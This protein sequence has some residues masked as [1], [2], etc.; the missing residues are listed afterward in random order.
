MTTCEQVRAQLLSY[1][2]DLL[3][4]NEKLAAAAHLGSCEGCQLALA[5]AQRQQRLLAAAAKT[6]FPNVTFERPKAVPAEKLTGASTKRAFPRPFHFALAASIFLALGLAAPATW[7]GWKTNELRGRLRQDQRDLSAAQAHRADLEHQKEVKATALATAIAGTQ[8][9]V[10]K[11]QE[12]E[13]AKLIALNKRM[14]DQQL[15]VSVIGPEVLQAGAENDYTINTRNLQNEALTA[16]LSASVVD[17]DGKVFFELKNAPTLG[18]YRLHLPADLPATPGKNLSLDVMAR[19]DGEP[20]RQLHRKI[21]LAAPVYLTHLATDKPMYRPGETVHF[22]SLTLERFSLKPV[23]DELRLQFTITGPQ[24][25]EIMKQLGSSRLRK[26]DGSTVTMTDGKPVAGIGAGEFLIP[27]TIAG[28]EFTLKVREANNRFPEQERKF[29]V[30]N[31]ANPRLNKELDFTRKSYGPGQ[32]V[33]AACS[34]TY[35]E[36][37]PVANRPVIASMFIDGKPFG[38]D[39]KQGATPLLLQ[40]DA[41]GKVSV[42]FKLPAVIDRGQASLSVQFND[43]GSVEPLIRTVPIALKKLMV[44]FFPEGGYLI[45]GAPNRVYFQARTTLGKPAELKGHIVD[46]TGATVATSVATLHDDSKPGVNQGMGR[47]AFTPALGHH[48]ELKIDEPSGM[49]GVYALPTLQADGVVLN[50]NPPGKESLAVQVT[51][52][53]KD[54]NLLIGVYC[55]G[56]LL[57]HQTVLA[58]KNEMATVELKPAAPTGGVCRVTVFEELPPGTATRLAPKAERLVYRAPGNPLTF[59]AKPNQ[60]RYVP[61]DHVKL[62]LSAFDE[63]E[64]A[65]PAVAMAAVVDKSVLTL[66]D[67]KTFHG[68]PTHYFLSTEIRRP[69]ELEYADFLVGADPK[70]P[71]ALDLLLGTQ[72]WRKFAEQHPAEF[73]KEHKEDADRLLLTM[74]QAAPIEVDFAKQE[75]QQ[76]RDEYLARLDSLEKDRKE[77][78]KSIAAAE[79]KMPAANS[80]VVTAEAQEREASQ[81]YFSHWQ[82][83]ETLGQLAWLATGLLGLAVFL[84]CL[85]LGVAKGW[86]RSPVFYAIGTLGLVG[87]VLFFADLDQLQRSR[88]GNSSKQARDYEIQPELDGWRR[89]LPAGAVMAPAPAANKADAPMRDEAGAEAK[90]VDKF[91]LQDLE[92]GRRAGG[93]GNVRGDAFGGALGGGVPGA[94]GFGGGGFGDRTAPKPGGSPAGPVIAGQPNQLFDRAFQPGQP[95]E[96]ARGAAK[97]AGVTRGMP[98]PASG[99]APVTP[100]GRLGEPQRGNVS[101]MAATFREPTKDAPPAAPVVD[102]AKQKV[103]EQNMQQGLDGKKASPEVLPALGYIIINGQNP[104][105]VKAVEKIIDA[106]MKAEQAQEAKPN[107]NQPLPGLGA[108]AAPAPAMPAPAANPIGGGDGIGGPGAPAGGFG[109]GQARIHTAGVVPKQIDEVLKDLAGR[110]GKLQEAEGLFEQ[111]FPAPEP[112]FV[113]E[114]AHVRPP[115]ISPGERKDFVDTVYW[116]PALVLPNGTLD[117][118]FQL[119]DAVTSYQLLV[120]GH[121]EDGRIGS[122]VKTFEARLPFTL[123]PKLP[124]E[125]T[126]GDRI[127]M[128]V[129]VAN[130]T[131]QSRSVRMQLEASNM[132]LLDKGAQ[133][134]S[135]SAGLDLGADSR[136]RTLFSLQP[137]AVE[138]EAQIVLE[139]FSDP[140]LDRVI[141]RVPI[142]PQGF[143]VVQARSDLLEGTAR[144]ELVLPEAWIP[145]T[146]R[147]QVT[148]YPSTL[149]SLQKGLEGLLREPNG[150]FEQTSTTNY[151][152]LLILDYLRESNQAKPELEKRVRDLLANGYAKLTSFECFEN[153]PAKRQG[154]EWFGGQAAPHEA[155]TA[156][157]LLQFRDMARVY[158][159]DKAMLERTRQYLVA[160]KD[161]QGGFQRNARALDSFGRAPDDVTNAYIVWSLTESGKD[162]DVTKELNALA[163]QSR[164]AQDPYFLALVALSL[165][166]RERTAEGITLLKTL[167]AAQKEDGHLDALRTSITG[168]G[169]R[170]LQI[171]TTALA[172]LG[173]LKANRP[174]EFNGFTQKA[175]KWIGQQRGGYG[176]FGSTQSTIL[177]LKALIAFAKMNKRNAEAGALT[178]AVGGKVA[179]RMEFPAGAQDV[180]TLDLP[181]ASKV[182]HAGNNDVQ[183]A[184]SGQNQFPYTLAWSYQV[185]SPPAAADCAVQVKTQLDRTSV[186]EGEAVHLNVTLENKEDFGQGMTVAI[187]GLP[188]GLTLPEDMKQLKD[189]SRLR[190][191]GAKPGL[192][193]AWETRGRELILYWRDLAPKQK[194]E[195]PIDLI[196]RVP[197]DYTGP[198]SRAYLYYNADNKNWIKP[199]HVT[200]AARRAVIEK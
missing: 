114:F 21:P 136:G 158:D 36:G 30:N 29:I 33:V 125:V 95:A 101:P 48:Y 131:S 96:R 147:C 141:R 171:E 88:S 124:L 185:E 73:R 57:D 200:I 103:R 130:N 64:Q 150:C 182:L 13:Q 133:T 153:G 151:P 121:T 149:A 179:A 106:R 56:R 89:N 93:G 4:D 31:F 82:S 120:F 142:V 91:G 197:G 99:P 159:V 7:F 119:G 18:S 169:G 134:A 156:Y 80:A 165:I 26:A 109:A 90:G 97:G 44:D 27:P 8:N 87:S 164:T 16:E 77:L 116:H 85:L 9:T 51:S 66:A 69:E 54:R 70:A 102:A 111:P 139:G 76:V 190:E 180:M 173:W 160:R 198:A 65:V 117:V 47:F 98:A 135:A 126:A 176:A 157:G 35:A 123:E 177:A 187:I 143:P 188:A 63:K 128:P 23:Q 129:S 199:L 75:I 41:L 62:G 110:V 71:E 92:L 162:D 68:M 20:T 170:D 137:T 10:A 43:G 104:E 32:E 15:Q 148:V 58:K 2:Y 22:R 74:G 183:V 3:D 118:E 195:V 45:A 144:S 14:A 6:A 53:G 175:I 152:N 61:G 167:G 146:L 1:V 196:A 172:V 55:R 86:R 49:E 46:E 189:H 112:M 166:N 140:Y 12:E 184:I 94:A 113:R 72:G 40:T 83:L 174:A 42:R 191:D 24:G 37:G 127:D 155:L 50:V 108:G 52:V 17:Q 105:D 100:E 194:I 5:A 59:A 39:G 163:D 161:G 11:I 145:G 192:I 34:A 186:D 154:Y 178:L 115:D 132:K 181:E 60:E 193:S 67:E 107:A 81:A 19:R 168:S 79:A 84:G 28:G 78:E 138:G 122:L 25:E 38:P